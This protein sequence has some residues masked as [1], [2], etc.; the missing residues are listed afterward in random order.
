LGLFFVINMTKMY[1]A[2]EIFPIMVSMAI[3]FIRSV[4]ELCTVI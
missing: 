3:D 4:P 1:F 2:C